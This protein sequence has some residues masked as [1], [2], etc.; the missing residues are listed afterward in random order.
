MLIE[1][2][3]N[4]LKQALRGKDTIKVSTLRFL[5]SAV[6]NAEIA[7]R[8]ELKDED[9]IA[10][11]KKQIKQRQES[12]EEFKKGN[13]QDLVDKETKELQILK[14]YLPEELE[15]E[16]LLDMVK[17]AML[18]TNATSVRDMGRVMK[19]VMAKA[20]GKADG[21]VVSELVKKELSKGEEPAGGDSENK[22]GKEHPK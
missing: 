11:I 2:I 14:G 7:K 15:P 5:K 22:Q 21:E 4:D 10:V 19:E 3:D 1:K 6:H 18:K 16:V 17:E 9:I 8:Q 13:R 20:K 12:I